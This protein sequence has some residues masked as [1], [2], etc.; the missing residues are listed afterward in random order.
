MKAKLNT[1]F[2]PP[3]PL[4]ILIV[5]D[6][7]DIRWTLSRL[8][9][10]QG[11]KPVTASSGS[12][13]LACIKKSRPDAVLM[14][15]KLPGLSGEAL[16][17]SINAYANGIPIIVITGNHCTQEAVKLVKAGIYDYLTKPFDNNRVILTI[18]HAVKELRLK[19]EAPCLR[20][21]ARKSTPLHESMGNSKAIQLIENLVSRVADTDFTVLICG[22]TG[23][24]KELVARAVHDSS[25]RSTKLFIAVDCGAIPETLMESELFGHEKGA[26]TGADKAVIGA[27]ELATGGTLFLDEIENM[28]HEMQIKLLRVLETKKIHRVGSAR[29][30][31]VDFRIVA[32]TNE[33][34]KERVD[35]KL[36]RL[37]LY[38]R[39]AEFFI[40]IPLL[41]DRHE[42]LPFLVER[43]IMLVNQELKKNVRG[44]SNEAWELLRQH[45]WPG[46]VR[47][48]RNV[49]RRGVL[50]C[51]GDIIASEHFA[52]DSSPSLTA[53]SQANH[54]VNGQEY[55]P[56]QECSLEGITMKGEVHR[57]IIQVERRLLTR[58]LNHS[59]GNKAHAARLLQID[60]KTIHCKLKEY[61]IEWNAH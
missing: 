11:W 51:D 60:Y 38:H 56:E 46:N 25:L 19:Q 30:I 50:L 27:I 7:E 44:L 9:Q 21:E 18:H 31:D 22:A 58:A 52:L 17:G 26:Y 10:G 24:G 35:K 36:F 15:L 4:Q 5:D 34:L 59:K 12:E 20:E 3:N 43:M 16:V 47:E 6:E 29:E 53:P 40:P 32:A 13:A 55:S 28:P 41:Q 61:G 42:D 8:I 2:K 45:D 48:L 14:D 49:I 33:N 1:T 39:L 57:A 37:D 54:S 23:T